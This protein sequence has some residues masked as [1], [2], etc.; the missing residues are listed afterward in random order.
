MSIRLSVFVMLASLSSSNNITLVLDGSCTQQNLKVKSKV[1][2]AFIN[3]ENVCGVMLR[4][5][6]TVDDV[7]Y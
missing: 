2:S 7:H 6:S 5:F 3:L 1:Y 4:V